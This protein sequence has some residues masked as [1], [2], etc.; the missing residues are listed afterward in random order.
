M[1]VARDL[2]YEKTNS[3]SKIVVDYL[4]E[5]KLLRSFYSFPPTIDG[6]KLAI[7][8]KKNHRINRDLLVSALQKQYANVAGREI[9]E[10]NIA[11]LKKEN[12]FTVCTAHQPNLFTG[13][14]YFIYKILHA[15]K[16]AAFL[17]ENIPEHRFVPVF[18]MGCEDAD[19]EELN[20]FSVRGKKYAWDTNQ[21]GAVGR[22]KIDKQLLQ[23]IDELDKQ[24]SVEPFGGEWAELL[25]KFFIIGRDIQTA[26][27]ELV[28]EL[29]GKYGLLV[30]IPDSADLKRELFPVFQDDLFRHHPL[31]IV[32]DTSK[33]LSELYNVQAF[34]RE[35]NLFYLKDNLRERIEVKNGNYQVLNSK[36]SFSEDELKIELHDHPERFSPNVIL[37]GLLQETVLPNVAFIGGGGELAYWL[38]LKDLFDHYEVPFPVQVLRNSFLIIENHQQQLTEKLNLDQA[39]MFQSELEILNNI[40]DREGKKPELNGEVKDLE[41]IYDQ[42]KVIASGYDETLAQHVQALKA[43]TLNQIEALEKKMF[44]AERKKHEAVK[45]QIARLKQQLFPNDSLQER[46]ENVG[47][48]YAK[49][50]R[51]FIDQL[52]INSFALEQQFVILHQ[53]H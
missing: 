17:N 20:H 51:S 14:L 32:S 42:L 15:I 50:G 6:I 22:M 18:Y 35:I 23:L 53:N 8:K 34:A 10:K 45:R 16:L 46:V 19:V 36:I 11:L 13:P 52:Y 3:F 47:W 44:R 12:T 25:R 37:R 27:F 33:K 26:T 41:K 2:P 40:I 48:Y 29:F 31:Q 9:V 5:N 24:L 49:W 39:E 21:K 7:E 4:A 38:Q 1:F 28:H 30:L 43:K